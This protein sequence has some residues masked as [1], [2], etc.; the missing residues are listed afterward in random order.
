[1]EHRG[2][3]ARRVAGA[4]GSTR[5]ALPII[6]WFRRGRSDIYPVVAPNQWSG[7]SEILENLD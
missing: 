4:W 6:H 5:R 2:G 3:V 1:L 7:A